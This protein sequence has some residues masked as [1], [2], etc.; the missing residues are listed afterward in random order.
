MSKLLLGAVAGS[1]LLLSAP[2]FA[3][4]LNEPI[5]QAPYAEPVA[6]NTFD[7]TGAYVGAD[8]GYSWANKASAA[9]KD[10]DAVVG[11]VFAGYNYQLQNNIVVGGEGEVAYGGADPLASYTGAVRGR[12]GYAFDNILVYGTVGGLVGQGE[13][14]GNGTSNTRTHVGYQAGAGLEAALTN[15][16]TARAEYLYTGTNERDYGAAGGEADLSG[17]AVKFGVA[18]KF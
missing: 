1:V 18:Y 7:W 16:I 9:G 17:N 4:D 3:A 12:V 8:V 11:G 14:K 15:N 10:H 13:M 5:P 6:S 2:V